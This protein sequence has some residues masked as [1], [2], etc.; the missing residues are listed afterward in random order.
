MRYFEEVG[1]RFPKINPDH[2][3]EVYKKQKDY[4]ERIQWGPFE[5]QRPLEEDKK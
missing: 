1:A 5:G 4:R 3:P 2:D